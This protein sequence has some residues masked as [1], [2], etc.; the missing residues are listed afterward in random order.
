MS[1]WTTAC[2]LAIG[3]V[4]VLYIGRRAL[5]NRSSYP[6]PPGPP[7][8]PWIGNVFGVDRRAPWKT[9]AEWARTYGRLQHVQF[10]VLCSLRHPCR[11][12]GLFSAVGKGHHHHQFRKGCKG[13]TREPVQELFRSTIPHHLRTV[14]SSFLI[15]LLTQATTPG[16]EWTSCPFF[17]PTAIYGDCTGAFSTRHL[18][19]MRY[20]DFYPPSTA[21]HVNSSGG[22]SLRPN[23]SMIMCSSKR[24]RTNVVI[25]QTYLSSRY[26]T[27]VIM[28]SAYDYDPTSPKDDIVDIVANVL[29]IIVPLLR[30]D[31]AVMVGAFPWCE[32]IISTAIRSRD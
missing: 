10:H 6:L 30:P 19:S 11:R 24:T 9:Y 3:S 26:T 14:R 28:N 7:G 21:R 15:I 1:D 17:C 32:P 16:V 25:D 8:L 18:G 27:A 4:V 2:A 29:N 31:I 12:L 20:T 13:T 23:N 5:E 22:C